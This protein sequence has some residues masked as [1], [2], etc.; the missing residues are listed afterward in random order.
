MRSAS[1]QL[2]ALLN[3]GAL[4][5]IAD[6][7]TITLQDSTVLRWTSYDQNVTANGQPFAMA[8]S[9][10]PL[11]K[12]GSIRN[13]RG[14]E[15]STLSIT[16]ECGDSVSMYG[17]PMQLAAH[18]GAFDNARVKVERAYMAVP[19]DASAGTIVLFEGNVADVTPNATGVDL[20]VKDDLERLNVKMPKNLFMPGCNYSVFNAGC[21]LAKATY[22]VTGTVTGTPSASSIPS[23][24]G[25]AADY[26]TLGVLTMT[27]GA[28]AGASRAVRAFANGTFTLAM[29]LPVAPAAGD[30]FTVYPGCDKTAA[31]C[32][33]KFSNLARFRGFPFVPRN[34]MAR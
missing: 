34:T 4:F 19:N 29:P 13:A 20:S 18:N 31:M 5:Y 1:T 25:E 24:R 16:L 8:G 27:S 30:T 17:I 28:A 14:L 26:Y 12:R 2:L 10:V 23:A 6:L 9:T 32:A 11:I 22:Q 15:V 21:G 33:A 7:F 3:S